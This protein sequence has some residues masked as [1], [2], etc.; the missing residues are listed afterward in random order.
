MIQCVLL[1]SEDCRCGFLEMT[2]SV[3]KL[4]KC[5]TDRELATLIECLCSQHPL[6]YS[7]NERRHRVE[8]IVRRVLRRAEEVWVQRFDQV[9]KVLAK[10]VVRI[11]WSEHPNDCCYGKRG[12]LSVLQARILLGL[13]EARMRSHLLSLR[14]CI[15]NRLPERRSK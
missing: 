5:A 10:A 14:C 3:I 15:G 2:H 7:A 11:R 1:G 12:L 13:L 6:T 4:D 9:R 8:G